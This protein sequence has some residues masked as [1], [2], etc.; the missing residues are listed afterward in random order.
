MG[1]ASLNVDPIIF[2]KGY[3]EGFTVKDPESGDIQPFTLFRITTAEGEVYEGTSGENGQTMPIYT[4]TPSSV[5]IEF[6]DEETA[7][8]KEGQ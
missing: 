5:K 1:P 6:P 8:D 4:A 7:D 3:G 2:P